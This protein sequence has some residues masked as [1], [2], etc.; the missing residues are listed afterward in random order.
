MQTTFKSFIEYCHGEWLLQTNTYILHS[1]V[2]RTYQQ[3]I[4]ICIDGKNLEIEDKE[5]KLYTYSKFNLEKRINKISKKQILD[6]KELSKVQDA[7]FN[8][9]ITEPKLLRSSVLINDQ[10]LVYE[11]YIYLID[12]NMMIS[13][14]LMKRFGKSNYLTIK[15]TS[16]IKLKANKL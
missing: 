1:K 2:Q 15:L 5:N 13:V 12:T 8:V 4:I 7:I 6:S 9:D 11:E 16:H 3:K 14:G 10:H